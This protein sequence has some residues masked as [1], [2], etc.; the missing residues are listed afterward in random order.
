MK[1]SYLWRMG[2]FVPLACNTHLPI[3]S[4]LPLVGGPTPNV[5]GILLFTDRYTVLFDIIGKIALPMDGTIATCELP[6][7]CAADDNLPLR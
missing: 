2:N 1:P 5:A 4:G 6:R 3:S 7:I